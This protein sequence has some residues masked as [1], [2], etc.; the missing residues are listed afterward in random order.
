MGK[1]LRAVVL[2]L[3]ILTPLF[4]F[5]V[6]SSVP[7]QGIVLIPL[8]HQGWQT[9]VLDDSGIAGEWPSIAVDG[10]GKL[11]VSYYDQ[12]NS[13]LRYATNENGKWVVTT[14]DSPG[15]VGE[16]SSI[17]VD[18]NN[19]VH[20]SYYDA[21][22]TNLKYATNTGGSWANITLDNSGVVGEYSSIAVDSN[23]KV[24][25]SY[26]DHSNGSLR[27]ITNAGGS[28]VAS[29]VDDP[30]G[31]NVG[32]FTSI[33]LDIQGKV[34]ISYLDDTNN[35]IKYATNAGGSWEITS[36][37]ATLGAAGYN[38]MALDATG[39]AQ[40]AYWITPSH[41][42]YNATNAGGA[43]TTNAVAGADTVSN[44]ISITF[45]SGKFFMA[46]QDAVQANLRWAV[47][48]VGGWSLG[49]AD[50][51]AGSGY[52]SSILVDSNGKMQIVNFDL[53]AQNLRYATNGGASWYV[54]T[55]DSAGF[56]G[57]RNSMAIDRFN[58]VH[59]AYIDATLNELKYAHWTPLIGWT[60]EVVDSSSLPAGSETSIAVDES[61]N[62]YIS[63]YDG[64]TN[65]LK[66]ANNV[67]GA[68]V[69]QT[70]VGGDPYYESMVLDGN[71]RAHIFFS[72]GINHNVIY[73]NHTQGGSWNSQVIDSSGQAS[74]DIQAVM[75]NGGK[76][77]VMYFTDNGVVYANNVG[78]SWNKTIIGHSGS[79]DGL[80]ISLALDSRGAIHAI[81][82]EASGYIY[83]TTNASGV[84]TNETI[85]GPGFIGSWCSI[86]IGPND[87]VQLA[88]ASPAD[89]MMRFVTIPEG[90][91]MKQIVDA[92]NVGSYGQMKLD[93]FGRAFISFYDFIAGD[94]RIES[95]VTAPSAP[96]AVHAG[97]SDK[98]VSLSWASPATNGGM[99][100]SGY[101]I[102]GGTSETNLAIIATVAGNQTQF[103]NTNLT[104]G[105]QR[106]YRISAVN[107]EGAGIASLA[108]SSTPATIPGQPLNVQ[109]KGVDSAVELSWNVPASNGGSAVSS[110][111]IYRGT[112]ESN[113]VFLT[114]VSSGSTSYKDTGLEN[115]KTYFYA[116][117]AVN[118]MGEG[119]SA[120]AVS[121]APVAFDTTLIIIGT[122]AVVAI[123][124]VA[125]VLMM[126]RKK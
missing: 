90:V 110:Y 43:W 103:E 65:S 57:S 68:W 125:V 27:Y 75:D 77:H 117:S 100:V 10:N 89:A 11:H 34:H 109:A 119:A 55:V 69:N 86:G 13:D 81:Y 70:A 80:G 4:F 101:R 85:E 58:N 112:N 102:Y 122:I 9:T 113:L 88:Y 64:A 17:A 96:M 3:M 8:P 114:N 87:V 5:G 39:K 41:V 20:I 28:W 71:L 98:A 115:G 61:G 31:A 22:N 23:N 118:N 19:K 94:L 67:G 50:V 15:V 111:R 30:L 92:N 40:I 54:N 95:R 97:G 32:E 24:H 25:V 21:V 99:V 82:R 93:S 16:Y 83:Y 107:W 46:Y 36:I 66:F 63:Y 62:A 42:L 49:V 45:N 124:G 104:N 78:G 72:D 6:I 18:S 44:G 26:Y 59:I 79:Y 126:R 2:A 7:A 53:T 14:V 35:V 38:D 74:G 116:V 91:W 105:V 73:V 60:T 56:T 120:I 51:K 106:F 29:P 52:Q 48:G 12:M 37:M 108:V 47:S 121:A 84:W 76:L 1:T 33:A 123:I